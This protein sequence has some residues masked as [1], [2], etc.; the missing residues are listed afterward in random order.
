MS[1]TQTIEIPANRRVTLEIPREIP[2]G[3]VILTFTPA[4]PMEE[5]SKEASANKPK[6][7]GSDGK[8]HFTR[9]EWDEMLESS[10]ITKEL[11]GILHTDMTLDEIRMARLAKHL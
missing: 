2:M 5:A 4:S 11:T 3:Q 10:P 1:V 9:K 7:V 6:T 8:F